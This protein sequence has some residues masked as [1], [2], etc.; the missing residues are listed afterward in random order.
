MLTFH[1]SIHD[2]C[3]C[4][5]LGMTLLFLVLIEIGVLYFK[6]V[7]MVTTLDFK[8]QSITKRAPN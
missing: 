2:R 4:S 6:G 8:Q 5:L 7:A 3:A 1:V